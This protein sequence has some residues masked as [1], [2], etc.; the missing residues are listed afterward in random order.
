[1]SNAV[2]Q[3]QAFALASSLPLS[4]DLT[5]YITFAQQA[6][7]SRSSDRT[8]LLA[9]IPRT[10]EPS[11]GPIATL[12]SLLET[13]PGPWP[14]LRLQQTYTELWKQ[15]PNDAKAG[16]APTAAKKLLDLVLRQC[17][18][19]YSSMTDLL[20]PTVTST[21]MINPE[22]GN[23]LTHAELASCVSE[24]RLPVNSVPGQTKPV[25]AI[26][27]PNGPTLALTVLAV[28][29]FYTAAPVAHGSGVGAE[30]FK[31]DIL[32]SQTN[33][34][35]AAP[36]DVDRLGLR[37]PWLAEA[38]IE[39][40]LVE[41]SAEMKLQVRD[42]TG[43]LRHDSHF[44]PQPIPNSADDIGI[45]LF[46]SGTSGT[47]KL[48]PL[49]THSLICGAAMVIDSWGL[50]PDMRCLN[51][52]PL[53][54]VGG[55][56]RNLFSPVMS[57][58]SVICCAAYDANLFWDCVEDHAPT[59]YYASPSMHQG[60]LEA[61]A[62]RP[63]TVAKSTIRLICNAAGGLLPS[64]A[65][66]LKDTFSVSAHTTV[67]PSYGMTECMPISTPPLNYKLD[68]TGTSGVSVGP[69]ISILDGNDCYI[70]DETVGRIA[71]RG[72][73]VFNGYL[74]NSKL[75]TSCFTDEGWFD[76]GDMG[77]LD[78]DGFLYITG[79]SK[80]VINRGGELISPF[81]VE[82]A[83]VAAG[84]TPDSPVYG[85][86]SKALAFSVTHDVL[87]E[88]VGIAVVTPEGAP[89]AD[90]RGLTEAVKSTLSSV[91]I[92]VFIVYMDAGVPTNNNK[93]LR[94]KLADRLDLPTISD[95]TP[96][97]ERYYEADCPPNNTPLKEPIASR[98]MEISYD[99]LWETAQQVLPA[100]I[101]VH[102]REDESG[103]YPQLVLAPTPD[104][105]YPSQV[106]G[107]STDIL[108]TKLSE[109]LPG[110]ITPKKV[111]K[112]LEPFPR[113]RH[114]SVDSIAI[115][116]LV[117]VKP[118]KSAASGLSPTEEKIADAFSSILSVPMG[119][120]DGDSDFFDLGGDSMKAGRLLS[121]LRKE[122]KVRLAID[123]LFTNKKVSELGRILD[124]KIGDEKKGASSS[125]T[126]V[127]P[128]PLPGL[129][130]T[131]SSTKPFLMMLQLVP[132]GILYPMK[133]A[134]TWTVFMYCMSYTQNLSI[135]DYVPGRLLELV[136]SIG[137]G[138]AVTKIVAPL[139]SI[140]CKWI[141]IGRHKEG[142]YPMW[143]RY[144][145][146]WWFV[147]KVIETAGIG[148]FGSFNWTRVLYYRLL[149]ASIG[150]NVT[151][152]LGAK[153]G[154]YDLINIGDNVVLERCKVRPFA[155]ERNTSMYLGRIDI[156][157][158]CSV[159]VAS[160]VAAGANMP[161]NTC[162]GPNSSNWEAS[163][164]DESNRDLNQSNIPRGHWL[165]NWT[166]GLPIA[167]VIMFCGCIPWLTAL[168]GMV[169]GKPGS[170]HP[171]ALRTVLIWF[172]EP[173]RVGFHYLAMAAHSGVGPYFFFFAFLAVKSFFDACM[174][175]IKPG[176]SQGQSN[177]QKFR[178][179]FMNQMM[180]ASQFHK[181]SELFGTHY[182]ATSIFARMLGAKI[183]KHVYW[184][185]TG[186]TVQDWDLIEIGNDVVFGSRSHI[187]TTDANGSD[188]V[189]I[190]SGAMVADR[191]VLLPG[192]EMGEKT[193]MGS[194]ALTRR[195]GYY[196]DGTTWVG[197]KNG[198]A[199]CL[200]QPNR[201]STA[202][203][204]SVGRRTEHY[205]DL[206]KACPPIPSQSL[207]SSST[208][209]VKQTPIDSEQSSLYAVEE[210]FELKSFSNADLRDAERANAYR[211][212]AMVRDV[213]DDDPTAP[214]APATFEEQSASPFGRAF[215]QGQASYRV[216]G[217][218]FIF[219]Y[220]TLITI[221]VAVYWN[222]GSIGAVQVLGH[223]VRHDDYATY[224]LA[225]SPER[226]IIIYFMFC[227]LITAIMAAQSVCALAAIIAV[228]WILMGRRTQGNY[229][230]D[231]SPYCQRW[232][233]FL[234]FEAFRRS[235]YGGHGILG[236][237][238][239][240]AWIPMYFRCLGADI[241]TD[242][243]I[244]SSGTPSLYF[245]E[246]DLLHLG[247]RVCVDDASLVGHINTRGK[248][249]LNPLYVGDRSVLRSGSRLLSGARMEPDTCLLEH[250]LVMAGDIVDQG[251]TS[252][253]WPAEE[254]KGNRMPTLKAQ[255]QWVIAQ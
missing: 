23:H 137:I 74:K 182:E 70:M 47:K 146:R 72:S 176:S 95:N 33:L 231:K 37:E 161:A 59:W 61:G 199:L 80:E 201:A 221:C 154:E 151:I 117:N 86:I 98:M 57:G 202:A 186:P 14:V 71:V 218:G 121:A 16:K 91:K 149:G 25:V 36:A 106:S 238:T 11:Y 13:L 49:F 45:M 169:Y 30:Q 116:K 207:N 27:L 77:Y 195:N 215:Y 51:Q 41:L 5:K 172:S 10:S 130:E 78:A 211:M 53:N 206:N 174:G 32:Q 1:M 235:C 35:L 69:E 170:E 237:L 110:Y 184:P 247:N 18:D 75:D 251:S 157:N 68:R 83:V 125:T 81:E 82:E 252:Q 194:G 179:D 120:L 90:L 168:V 203:A 223:L 136:V 144:H 152:V 229:D 48:V 227:A 96:P 242:C 9:Q 20:H 190:N 232:Q 4:N 43:N 143:G 181:L 29:S 230:W 7:S 133:R 108:I 22:D 40:L 140:A 253:G 243:S 127:E 134:L 93:V 100:D 103:F 31:S 62:D 123:V 248:F 60:I 38:S 220:A 6:V 236:L 180:P 94:I 156:G 138:K 250:T 208:T 204:S 177:F 92:P 109:T 112:L 178:R 187:V 214:P 165:L 114:G 73:P 54:H 17:K 89:R 85:R 217:Q 234:K 228:K 193:V 55:L 245:T 241:G 175:R 210:G 160:S 58:G 159:G 102:V 28:A 219:C 158:N 21:A 166:I 255:K 200:S 66:Q 254:F 164:A 212:S 118:E 119:D 113:S 2:S 104:S 198:E 124:A 131:C 65:H 162:I 34:V 213:P 99:E 111:H 44:W 205:Y 147:Q 19:S 128:E 216:W 26:S 249:D 97:A 39:V 167:I 101:D 209:L 46:T 153:L 191:V 122:F 84:A 171:D 105:G 225:M 192:V 233:L 222:I 197:S 12:S 135:N 129:D 183:G 67:L 244:F 145:T 150:N 224:V 148:L 115:E 42:V 155:A 163:G 64:L 76:T 56:V 226:P 52:M 240:T 87:Q 50:N 63:E 185:G 189:K 188:R 196:A 239:G 139:I 142:L 246:P 107:I 132:I 173:E 126:A 3:T 141:V 24:F 15:L 79:R 8:K 88:V